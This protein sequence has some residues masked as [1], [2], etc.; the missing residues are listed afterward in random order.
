MWETIKNNVLLKTIAILTFGVLGFGL[1]FNIMF[2]RNTGMMGQEM[3]SG[4]S[5]ESTLAYILLILVKLLLIAIVLTAIV[6]LYK[7]SK[8][9]LFEGRD[10][11]MFET[12]KNDPFVKAVSVIVASVLVIAL[13]AML[14]SNIFGGYGMMPNYNYTMGT[15]GGFGLASMLIF[16]VKLLMFV[17]VVGLVA[18]I[19]FYIIQ[20]PLNHS[21][22]SIFNGTS[23]AAATFTCSKCGTEMKQDWKCCPNCGEEMGE[24]KPN[25]ANPIVDAVDVVEV[26]EENKL[27]VTVDEP[28]TEED[29]NEDSESK[30]ATDVYE[31]LYDSNSVETNEETAHGKNRK[32]QSKR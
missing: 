20:T 16:L 7:V 19:I 21:I 5:L 32:K 28:E 9:Y 26:E 3:N 4:Y 31:K 2:G 22:G 27:Q 8:K 18:S 30:V 10:M 25:E 1:A 17:S 11:K 6:A 15:V 29:I 12:Y 13:I 23:K 14:F 24:C